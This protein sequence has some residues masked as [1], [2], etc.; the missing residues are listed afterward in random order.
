M[1][2]KYWKSTFNV[3]GSRLITIALQ[4][5]AIK[6]YVATM[7]AFKKK[8]RRV[9]ISSISPPQAKITFFYIVLYLRCFT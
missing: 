5:R 9:K 2:M 4:V 3:Q 6:I 7:E 8:E 1:G